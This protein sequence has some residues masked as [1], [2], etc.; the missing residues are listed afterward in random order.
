MY[1]GNGYA[2]QKRNCWKRSLLRGPGR[3]YITRTTGQASDYL[4]MASDVMRTVRES[5]E[6]I[7]ETRY[8]AETS[9]DITNWENLAY[10]IVIC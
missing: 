10:A 5:R 6:V 4:V 1:L 3:D 7:V 9:E 8:Q 2:Q